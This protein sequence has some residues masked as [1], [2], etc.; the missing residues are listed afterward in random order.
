MQIDL[1]SILHVQV[2]DLGSVLHMIGGTAA[3]RAP[4]VPS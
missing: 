2:S 1:N 3:V 4:P